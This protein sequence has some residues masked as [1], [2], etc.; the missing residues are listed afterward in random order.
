METHTES[1]SALWTTPQCSFAI[2]YFPRVLDDIRLAVVDAFFS[3]PRGG[4]EI[5]GI[6]LGSHEAKRVLI[7]DYQPLDCEHAFGPGFTLS[8]RDRMQL[9]E[10][11]AAERP[12]ELQPVGW[13]HSHTRSDIFLSDTDLEIYH[14]YFPEAWHVALV[15]KPHTFQPARAGF[16][17]RGAG[18]AIH[19][20]ASYREFVLQPLA[21]RPLPAPGPPLE[22]HPEQLVL[23]TS[24]N[25]IALAA[26]PVE[27]VAAPEPVS[28]PDPEPAI[29][30][31]AAAAEAAAEAA[32]EPEPEPEP[33]TEPARAVSVPDLPRFLQAGPARA[34]F[35]SRRWVKAVAAVLLGSAIGSAGYLTRQSWLPRVVAAFVRLKPAPAGSPAAPGAAPAA[36][37]SIGLNV[38]DADGQL[39]IRWDRAS[40]AVRN[41]SHAV[42]EILDSG[43]ALRAV[44]LDDAHLESGSFTYAREGARVDVALA[45][46]QPN[47]KHLRESTTFLGSVPSRPEDAAVLRRQRDDL[48]RQNMQLQADIKTIT[49]RARKLEKTLSQTE[50][51]LRVQQRGRLENQIPK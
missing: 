24:G 7:A 38:L 31:E 29:D 50:A 40:P 8:E 34:P 5:G 47:G 48:A 41:G 15:M 49:E 51:Q 36:P 45:L 22:P 20:T 11:L 27:E 4:A 33:E 12:R 16:F 14:Q 26:E 10:L 18:G 32:S 37:A 17:F 46:D 43:A 3:L 6:L 2:E 28:Q 39:Q 23:P 42:L 25:V 30:V 19:A 9:A 13:Y 35:W 21:V 1:G 44:P